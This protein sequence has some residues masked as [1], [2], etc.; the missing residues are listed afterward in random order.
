MGRK[1]VASYISQGAIRLD[2][3]NLPRKPIQLDPA[4]PPRKPIRLD[5]ANPPH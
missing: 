4:N 2:P 3:A 1:I 5:P